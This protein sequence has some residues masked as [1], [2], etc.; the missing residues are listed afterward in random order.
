M[1]PWLRAGSL[2][3]ARSLESDTVLRAGEIV[4]IRRPDRP[5]LEII[6]R[7]HSIDEAGT[8]FVLGDNPALSTDSRE[9]GAVAREH[10]VARVRWRYWPLP[11]R[12]L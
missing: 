4:V 3:I 10:V 7:I 11:P 2:V 8:I 1:E 9:F 5:G 6:K 12:R